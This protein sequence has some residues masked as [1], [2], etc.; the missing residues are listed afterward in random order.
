MISELK[1]KIN[2]LN[3]VVDRYQKGNYSERQFKEALSEQMEK[4]FMKEASEESI[5]GNPHNNGDESCMEC[6][7][8]KYNI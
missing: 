3:K 7:I 5:C 4:A 8:V 1:E 2:N 6:E